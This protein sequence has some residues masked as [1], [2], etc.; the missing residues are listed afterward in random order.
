MSDKLTLSR[1]SFFKAGIVAGISVY[2]A[3]WGPDAFAELFE[4]KLLTPIRWDPRN[5][6]T[7]FRIDGVAKVTGQKI[8]AQDIRARDM[9]HW[10]AHQSHALILRIPCADR[11]FKGID[12]SVLGAEL[13]PDRV[14]TATDLERDGLVLPEFYGSEPFLAV[15]KPAMYL[16]HPVAM[17]IYDD[18]AR[19]N[20]AKTKLKFNDQVLLLGDKA[21]YR[22]YDP[23]AS[24]RYVRVAGETRRS[25]DVYSSIQNTEIFGSY[26]KH[27]TVWPLPKSNGKLDEQ[28]MAYA[29]SMR[30]ELDAPPSNWLVLK[31]NYSSQSV[32][33]SAMEPDNTNGWYD[34][35]SQTLHLVI[36]SQS[37]A[38]VAESVSQMLSASHFEV[39]KLFIHPC[40]T[41]GYGSKDHSIFPLY[42]MVAALY[43]ASKPVRLANDR[44]EQFQ[45]TMKRHAFDMERTIAVDRN[46]GMFQILQSSLVG[47]GG[48]RA[49][50]SASVAGCAATSAQ[51]IYFFPR[52]DIDVVCNFSR[53]V[54]A[55]SMRGYGTLQSMSAT[56]MLV[57]ELAQALGMDAIDLRLKNALHSG[58]LN[59]QGIAPGG[60]ERIVEMLQKAKNH[61][62]WQQ[63]QANKQKYE[64][65]H[66]GQQYGVGFACVQ[67]DFGTG[68]EASFA[69]VEIDAKG[70]VTLYHTGT[71][72]G[73]GMSTSQAVNCAKWLGY[74]AEVV[75]TSLLSW[76]DLPLHTSGNPHAMSQADQQRLSRDPAWTPEMA[77]GAS[78]SNSA[79]YFSHTTL[80]ACRL[81]FNHGLWPAALSVWQQGIEGG[82]A[83]SYVLR[84]E[85][86]RWTPEG[87]TA[88]GMEPLPLER[89]AAIAH[90]KGL[91]TGAMT[92]GFNR[93]QWAEATFVIDGAL[94]RLP[95][96]GISLRR[97]EGEFSMVARQ[98]AFYPNVRRNF[99]GVT[100]YSGLSSLVELSVEIGTGKVE[101][102]SHHHLVD[103]GSPIVP[104]LVSGQLQ[105]GVAMGIGHAL[106]EYLPLYEDG[107]GNGTWNFNRYHLP[108]ASE[109]AVWHQSGELLP[110]LSE[111]DPSKGIAEVV[112]IPI[113]PAIVNAIHHA[114][115]Q[116]FYQLPVTAEK[117][118]EKL[119]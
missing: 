94:E 76:A 75:H 47:N 87:L 8:F 92:H 88:N 101:L 55:G 77:S 108:R 114:T 61:P 31:R 15:G 95:L 71:E 19:F 29:T 28:G 65:S 33:Q 12:L 91:I 32:D 13:Q 48:G 107:P 104:E 74:P 22:E 106:Y 45:S 93:W 111:T 98:Q 51:S 97:G 39:K 102:I 89:L 116:R 14:V 117:I 70:K 119:L 86:A 60:A 96:D 43:G 9:P 36:S 49:N 67:K 41:V 62:L 73:T 110:P 17:L 27:K 25:A 69:K 59:T 56:E 99:A 83:S 38:E 103:C 7:A 23:Y 21:A 24:Y 113:V 44:Y 6:K 30:A 118:R 64:A 11:I 26:F 4:E 57:D 52:N 78:A 16:G 54:E 20:T 109:V 80:E 115:G 40:H 58:D 3:P 85:D 53:A 66:P 5:H 81:I 90:Q 37:P 79:Y 68:A 1:R 34:T 84:R 10:P 105:G 46:T 35:V 112:M 82:P 2:I 50:Y 63:R 42:G 100:Y 72:I 18:F